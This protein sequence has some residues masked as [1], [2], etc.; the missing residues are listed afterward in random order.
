M[1]NINLLTLLVA[2]VCSLSSCHSPESNSNGSKTTATVPDMQQQAGTAKPSNDTSAQG[3]SMQMKV[4][5]DEVA[6][7][8]TVALG[9]MMEVESGK[10]AQANS[11]NPAVIAFARQMVTDHSRANAELK[12]LAENFRV[13]LPDAFPSAQRAHLDEMKKMKGATFDQHYMD[14]MIKDHAQTV[15]IFKSGESLKTKEIKDF[16]KKVLPTIEGHYATAKAL[17]I[18]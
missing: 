5:D 14:M 15:A 3:I 6:F 2:A 9:G 16:A 17:K 11:K 1:K 12:S 7:L 10:V 4:D 13:L 18:K 8:K